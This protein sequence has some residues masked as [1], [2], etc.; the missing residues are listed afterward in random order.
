MAVRQSLAFT[1]PDLVSGMRGPSWLRELYKQLQE[2]R[3][4][5]RPRKRTV[6]VFK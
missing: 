4:K 3:E 5:W 6:C 1:F 2:R